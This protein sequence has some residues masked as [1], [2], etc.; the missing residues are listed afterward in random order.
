MENQIFRKKSL[1]RIS[2]P[3]KL[4]DYLKVS[5]P[6]LWIVLLAVI[7]LL[8][9]IFVWASVGRLETT[10]DAVVTIENKQGQI[11]L[12]GNDAEKIKSGMIV[13]MDDVQSD[14]KLIKYDDLGRAIALCDFDVPDGNYKVQIVIESIHPISFLF[15]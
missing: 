3:E 10:I 11:V 1:E 7:A 14:I 6:S 15:R 5:T 9:G 4:D 12:T 2:S 13:N 8:V